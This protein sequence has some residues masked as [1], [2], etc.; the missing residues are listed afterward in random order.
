MKRD[1]MDTDAGRD[2]QRLLDEG[3]VISGDV[4]VKVLGLEVLPIKV[5]LLIGSTAPRRIVRRELVAA[6]CAASPDGS[7]RFARSCHCCSA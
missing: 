4:Q 2:V 3:V 7:S 6:R 1:Q 5:N